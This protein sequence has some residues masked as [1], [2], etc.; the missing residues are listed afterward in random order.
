MKRLWYDNKMIP[1]ESEVGDKLDI[2][3]WTG[4][5]E[6][7]VIEKK[8]EPFMNI[9]DGEEEVKYSVVHVDKILNPVFVDY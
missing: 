3:Y 1:H 8:V 7:A 2:V 5:E 9:P 6:E 4:S